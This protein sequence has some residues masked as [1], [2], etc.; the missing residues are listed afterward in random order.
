MVEWLIA[1]VLNS[2]PPLCELS[3]VQIPLSPFLGKSI[4]F[5]SLANPQSFICKAEIL[6]TIS[7]FGGKGQYILD[8]QPS[9]VG[10]GFCQTDEEL[11]NHFLRLKL[12]GGYEQDVSLIEEAN[13]FLFLF[14]ISWVVARMRFLG[15]PPAVLS[16]LAPEYF[17]HGKISDKTDVY[18]FGVVLLELITGRKP[19]EARRPSRE[20]NL[21]L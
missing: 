16:Y 8:F 3:R 6:G 7:S 13:V 10:Y 14:S 12:L 21:V 2:S 18:A 5:K 9:R 4:Y 19:F 20:E 15:V 17:Q 1:P 11:A